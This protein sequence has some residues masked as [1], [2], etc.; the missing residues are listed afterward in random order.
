MASLYVNW[1]FSLVN[2]KI[3]YFFV[4]LMQQLIWFFS[5]KCLRTLW[6]MVHCPNKMESC[7][8]QEI[9]TLKNHREGK[10]LWKFLKPIAFVPLVQWSTST[11]SN[12]QT[13]KCCGENT[14][15]SLSLS[16]FL[17]KTIFNGTFSLDSRRGKNHLRHMSSDFI[18][19]RLVFAKKAKTL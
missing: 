7:Q 12:Q 8:L 1:Q 13:N 3:V 16:V 15:Q 14:K 18:E 6:K 5:L 2:R 11:K 19:F 9:F 10:N 17:L 4:Q